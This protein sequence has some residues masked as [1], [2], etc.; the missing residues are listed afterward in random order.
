MLDSGWRSAPPSPRLTAAPSGLIPRCIKAPASPS[1]YPPPTKGEG[2]PS[3]G[4]T[5]RLSTASALGG[6]LAGMQTLSDLHRQVSHPASPRTIEEL[7]PSHLV[8]TWLELPQEV[9]EVLP[10]AIVGRLADRI[11]ASSQ[12]PLAVASDR[13]R[14][15]ADARTDPL[16]GLLNRRGLEEHLLHETDRVRRYSRPLAVL[17]VDVDCLKS[18]N[19][20]HG[21]QAGDAVLVTI[22]GLLRESVRCTD[23]VGRWAGDEFVVVCPET[24]AIAAHDLAST[25]VESMSGPVPLSDPPLVVPISLSAGWAMAVRG[26]GPSAVLASADE[27][28]YRAKSRGGDCASA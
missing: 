15:T 2:L 14:L 17:M 13:N 24:D 9:I 21:N 8:A 28:L 12:F 27:A 23:V 1:T 11:Q 19:D 16:T 7:Q 10:E 22:A 5:A 25:M 18:V 3:A 20:C 6:R 4:P 26:Q